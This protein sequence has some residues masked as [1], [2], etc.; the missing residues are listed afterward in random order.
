MDR[1]EIVHEIER[2]GKKMPRKVEAKFCKQTNSAAKE[3]LKSYHGTDKVKSK[4]EAAVVK[5]QATIRGML[6]RSGYLE[7]QCAAIVIQAGIRMHLTRRVVRRRAE[8][9]LKIQS[10][11]RSYLPL[12][13]C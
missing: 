2:Q 7:K 8:V 11:I 13:E 12:E 4:S 10:T 5:I 9:I 1:G 3:I 6:D